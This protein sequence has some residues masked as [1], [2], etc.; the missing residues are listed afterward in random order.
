M[1]LYLYLG[2]KILCTI[3]IDQEVDLWLSQWSVIWL[4]L[5]LASSQVP[6]CVTPLSSLSRLRLRRWDWWAGAADQALAPTPGC[7]WVTVVSPCPLCLTSLLSLTTVSRVSAAAR[8]PPPAAPAQAVPPSPR[9]APAPAVA[10]PRPPRLPPAHNLHKETGIWQY[11]FSRGF[12]K[13]WHTHKNIS[14][15][16]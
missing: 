2:P 4:F 11:A 5:V 14:Y 1:I 10:A 9:P 8:W 6:D 3:S 7:H 12:S 16:N 15:I 13:Y